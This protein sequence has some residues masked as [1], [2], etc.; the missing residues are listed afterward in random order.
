M[1]GYQD[2]P[3]TFKDSVSELMQEARAK[4]EDAFADSDCPRA[5]GRFVRSLWLI[6]EF[7]TDLGCTSAG[8]ECYGF[9]NRLFNGFLEDITWF[10]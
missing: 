5:V 9:K 3:K 2:P 8:C 7:C 4:D 10:E 6:R 1:G